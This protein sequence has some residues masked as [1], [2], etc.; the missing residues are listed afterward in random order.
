M[1]E[2]IRGAVEE[3]KLLAE[4]GF[5]AVIVENFGDAP[6]A[7][8]EVPPETVAGMAIVVDHVVRAVRVP[9]G[10]NVLRNDSLAALGVAAAA[11]AAF[12]RVNVLSGVYATDQGIITGRADEVMRRRTSLAPG[13]R[14]AADV[15]VKHAAPVSQPDIALAAEETAYRG[16]AD[17][18]IVSGTG[19]GKATDLRDA[20]RVRA[21]VAD[22]PVWIGSGVTPRTLG[23]CLAAASG[24]IVGTAQNR[25]GRTTAGI[26]PKRVRAFIAARRGRG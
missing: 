17:V 20:R 22:R 3:A 12:I 2:I 26:D 11:G 23:D 7:S 13:V 25:G 8:T 9:V 4:A 14:I 19:T 1:G 10:V 24:V 18:V 6:F 15:H 16:G 21:A 5:D